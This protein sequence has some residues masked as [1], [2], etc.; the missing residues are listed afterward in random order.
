M[1]RAFTRAVLF[2]GVVAFWATAQETGATMADFSG[3]WTVETPAGAAGQTQGT[4]PPSLSALGDMGSGWPVEI[5]IA[6]DGT[7]LTI[8]LGYFQP[9][10]VQP[11]VRLTYALD[12]RESGNEVNLG[13]GP[14]AQIARVTFRDSSLVLST[15]HMFV[16]PRDGKTIPVEVTQTLTLTSPGTMS[17]ETLRAGVLGGKSSTTR[18]VYRKRG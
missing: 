5:A 13:R 8:D 15:T 17:V 3:K 6:Q 4:A 1:R 7:N 18:T 12:G 11:T 2:L 16:H 9:R 10:D 14:Q